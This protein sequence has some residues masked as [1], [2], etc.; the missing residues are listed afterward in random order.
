MSEM[1]ST[2]VDCQALGPYGDHVDDGG[3]AG[4]ELGQTQHLHPDPASG[5]W[6]L[7]LSWLEVGGRPECVALEVRHI[8]PTGRMQPLGENV[9]RSMNISSRIATDRA[10]L[11]KPA[12]PLEP[13]RPKGMREET[14]ERLRLVAAIYRGALTQGH[15]PTKAVAEELGVALGTASATV[16]KARRLGLLPPTS[17]GVPLG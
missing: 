16:S 6:R 10:G 13:P 9:L 5:P 11:V 7:T 4:R 1:G 14:F 12:A 17:G 8:D 2:E 3:E 15:P